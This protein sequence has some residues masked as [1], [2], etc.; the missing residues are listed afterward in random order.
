MY[1]YIYLLYMYIY[2]KTS[3]QAAS[4]SSASSSSCRPVAR[5]R[6]RALLLLPQRYIS[7]YFCTSKQALLHH[8][9]STFV[10]VNAHIYVT[11]I[12]GTQPNDR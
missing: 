9:A 1:M 3:I 7:K 12:G 5:R 10:P 11:S 6:C 4:S 8:Q 2:S